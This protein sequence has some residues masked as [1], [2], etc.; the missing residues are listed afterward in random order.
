MDE[1]WVQ[2]ANQDFYA[3]LAF[4]AGI[5]NESTKTISFDYE[6]FDDRRAP[7]TL[8]AFCGTF[9]DIFGTGV[10]PRDMELCLLQD[11]GVL[12]GL[13]AFQVLPAM[14][15]ALRIKNGCGENYIAVYVT[16]FAFHEDSSVTVTIKEPRLLQVELTYSDGPVSVV[17]DAEWGGDVTVQ[18]VGA[19]R[20]S[21]HFTC[22]NPVVARVDVPITYEDLKKDEA[23]D[24]STVYRRCY[25]LQ[26]KHVLY[27]KV[28]PLDSA[29]QTVYVD[30]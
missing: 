3:N 16:P 10:T 27:L 6:S 29:Q 22:L 12:R 11:E 1:L 18:S 24:P 30:R 15:N 13:K 8:R 5:F 14:A 19:D 23:L 9:P 26:C 7:A 21:K 17:D 28:V 20:L 4:R 25:P 2:H